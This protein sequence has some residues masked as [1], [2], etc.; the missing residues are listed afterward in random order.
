MRK[1]HRKSKSH[2]NVTK[3]HTSQFIVKQ[4]NK[5]LL[6]SLYATNLTIPSEFVWCTGLM[7]GISVRR[8]QYGTI[9]HGIDCVLYVYNRT[10]HHGNKQ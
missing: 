8:G 9:W 4:A 6:M 2:N 5:W 7:Q 10:H 3:R 1:A